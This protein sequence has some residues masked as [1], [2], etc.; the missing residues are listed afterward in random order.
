MSQF[1]E[2]SFY[3]RHILNQGNKIFEDPKA[4]RL[5]LTKAHIRL[6]AFLELDELED[7]T[8][9]IEYCENKGPINQFKASHCYLSRTVG[10]GI[11]GVTTDI[12]LTEESY[13]KV[14]TA[15][16]IVTSIP[17]IDEVHF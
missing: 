6:D 15:L 2:I 13:Y 9:F 11:N 10:L 4:P 5:K 7:Y 12:Y 17:K 14:M 1:I 8:V 3:P 16:G